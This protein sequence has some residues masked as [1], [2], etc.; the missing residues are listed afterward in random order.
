MKTSEKHSEGQIRVRPPIQAQSS[1]KEGR[2]DVSSIQPPAF[3]FKKF[4]ILLVG[5]VL[6][7]MVA[8]T[9]RKNFMTTKKLKPR[10]K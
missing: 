9:V 5:A 7:F 4:L 10:R 8:A 2:D 3:S 1:I 6:L